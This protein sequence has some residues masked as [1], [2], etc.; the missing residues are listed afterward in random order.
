MRAVEVR[1]TGD[2]DDAR[3][4]LRGTESDLRSLDKTAKTADSGLKGIGGT[5]AKIG[6]ALLAAGALRKGVS[7]L[8][9]SV[10]LASDLVET[11]SKVD[12]VF[13][14]NATG[15]TSWAKTSAAALVSTEKSVLDVVSGFNI[16]LGNKG[17][18]G[19]DGVKMSKTL[20]DLSADLASFFNT[21]VSQAAGALTSALKGEM[22]PLEAYGVSLDQATLKNRAMEMGLVKTSVDMDKVKRAT[23]AVAQAQ[24]DYN[25]EAAKNG[26]DSGAAASALGYLEF[27]QTELAK[28]LK[29]T[30][31]ELTPQAKAM[32]AYAEILAQTGKAQGD[33]DRT[34]GSAANQMRAFTTNVTELKTTLG[35][36]F[37]PLIEE[38]L[39]GVNK[40][41]TGLNNEDGAKRL[42][43][44][45]LDLGDRAEE[46]WPRIQVMGETVKTAFDNI[47]TGFSG[48]SGDDVKGTFDAIAGAAE[49]MAGFVGD[50]V[51]AFNNMSP[52]AKENIL[53]LIAAGAALSLAKRNP[54]VKIG[55]DLVAGTIQSMAETMATAITTRMFSGAFAQRVIIV[56][57]PSVLSGGLG[58]GAAVTGKAGSGF[59]TGLMAGAVTLGIAAYIDKGIQE[60]PKIDAGL[61]SDADARRALADAMKGWN[62]EKTRF[63]TGLADANKGIST[64]QY[65]LELERLARLGGEVQTRRGLNELA[66][67]TQRKADTA[68]ALAEER[69]E[70]AALVAAVKK[71]SVER[72][73]ELAKAIQVRWENINKL[74]AEGNGYGQNNPAI[75]GRWD[76][77][78]RT[79]SPQVTVN[80]YY[81]EPERSSDNLAMSLRVARYMSG[82]S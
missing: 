81:P 37:T 27:K 47:K 36:A 43:E 69:K 22:D 70:T 20:T 33:L 28:A 2:S 38:Y 68:K 6:G 67:T 54:V 48:V 31:E 72:D 41:L 74:Y 12:V 66:A 35:T 13:G 17:V 51:G 52:E 64:Q 42:G 73:K 14:K 76:T 56:G 49:T 62:T 71:G 45:L 29:G 25:L 15:I 53:L 30:A 61:D 7:L 34:Q 59:L 40:W 11:T 23:A 55:V 4:A 18:T 16:L 79:R 10:G 1:V 9:E 82:G 32:A 58:G 80:N 50:A 26:K 60:S 8:K 77:T 46:L 57:P 19:P 24:A 44:Q 39:P 78:T 3:R 63:E 21:D 65:D 75:T 5:L